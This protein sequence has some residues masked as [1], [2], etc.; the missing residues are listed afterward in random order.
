M[1]KLS[2]L[3]AIV[4]FISV[5][6]AQCGSGQPQAVVDGSGN[7]FT[8]TKGGANIYSGPFYLEAINAAL[9]AIGVGERVVVL[10][11]GD[12]GPN[13]IRVTSGKT[14]EVCGTIT[15][16]PKLNRGAIEAVDST[17]VKIP[18][19]NLAGSPVFGLRFYGVTGLSL[20][21]INMNLK[22]GMGIRFDRD[23][24][25]NKD[26]SMDSITVTGASS[27]AIETWNIDGL[28]INSVNAKNVGE[29]GLLLQTTTNA[30]VKSVVCNNAGAGTGYACLRFAN[31]NGAIGGADYKTNVFVDSVKA[32]GGGRGLFCVSESGGAEVGSIDFSNVE[33]EP[34]LIEN[35]YNVNV[36]SGT[37]RGG[38]R[39]IRLS[40]RNSFKNNRDISIAVQAENVGVTERP[41]G[42]NIKL[43]I[44]GN[45]KKAIC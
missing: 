11:S 15:A 21:V 2:I 40:A 31:R 9:N 17:D 10:A 42:T 43:A 29:C 35:C 16:A 7:S 41:C 32:T 45:G 4:A 20:G 30:N 19:L 39:D 23:K 1:A 27:H 22:S 28:T 14:F 37:V 38:T 24:P 33:L 12:I 18:Y 44:T 6:S 13:S 34:I 8:A 3:S 5:A 25:P 26:V 36:A